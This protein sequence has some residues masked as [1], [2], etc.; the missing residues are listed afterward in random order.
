MAYFTVCQINPHKKS[1]FFKIW[2]KL[3][4]TKQAHILNFGN[5]STKGYKSFD[6]SRSVDGE[7]DRL[8]AEGRELSSQKAEDLI[9]RLAALIARLPDRPEATMEYFIPD[10]RKADGTYVTITSGVRH[11]S[12]PEKALVMEIGTVIPMDDVVSID[13]NIFGE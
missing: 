5:K 13:G 12:V 11:N 6:Y 3:K 1:R 2:I 4:N 8:S 10:D 9:R 7:T